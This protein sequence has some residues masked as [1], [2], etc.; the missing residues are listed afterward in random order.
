[1]SHPAF[2]LF[3]YAASRVYVERARAIIADIKLDPHTE[4]RPGDYTALQKAIA[5]TDGTRE[6]RA[7]RAEIATAMFGQTLAVIR[8]QEDDPRERI[9]PASQRCIDLGLQLS[10]ELDAT[11]EA[12]ESA[13]P[14]SA[15]DP[16][17]ET[18]FKT[19][20]AAVPEVR[21]R[22][23]AIAEQKRW[24][25]YERRLAT[26]QTPYTH[27][28]AAEQAARERAANDRAA[29]LSAEQ[30]MNHAIRITADLAARNIRPQQDHPSRST[31]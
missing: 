9:A 27:K 26:P 2:A 7:I 17:V 23:N 21:T 4:L 29:K 12:A 25:A 3:A 10:R 30:E 24:D 6:G 1:M 31:A 20:L 19:A 16:V 15:P 22:R 8:K 13:A 28:A 14:D 11:A 5:K 18:A